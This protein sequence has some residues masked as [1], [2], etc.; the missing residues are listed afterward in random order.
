MQTLAGKSSRRDGHAKLSAEK[1]R[2]G[3]KK[4]SSSQIVQQEETNKEYIAALNKN[5]KSIKPSDPASVQTA[6]RKSP[7]RDANCKRESPGGDGHAK[8][9]TESTQGIKSSSQI[10]PQEE[11]NGLLSLLK[12]HEHDTIS[13]SNLAKRSTQKS[14]RRQNNKT[15][16]SKANKSSSHRA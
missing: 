5:Y 8:R 9:G 14:T 7:G 1:S 13:S 6:A 16:S 4:K 15:C 11:P 2:D 3:I 12:L 10:V